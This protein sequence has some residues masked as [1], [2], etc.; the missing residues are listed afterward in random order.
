MS[1]V[2]LVCLAFAAGAMVLGQAAGCGPQKGAPAT[3]PPKII[4]E[5]VVQAKPEPAPGPKTGEP[6]KGAVSELVLPGASTGVLATERDFVTD[7]LVL[8]PLEFKESDFGGQ[9]QQAAADKEFM[10]NEGD[11]DGTQAA[12]KGT[13]WRVVRFT[14]DTRIGRVNL[15]KLYDAIDHA[16]AYAVAWLDCPA[17]VKDAKLLVGSDDYVKVW[18]N[19]R[20]VHTYKTERR[21]GAADQ[22]IV[23]G[24]ALKK[25][26][27]RV[28]VKCV[29]VVLDWDFY[30][31]LTDSA[32]KS[33][34]VKPKG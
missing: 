22:D 20:L 24:M 34:A 18:I 26:L 3:H 30:L 33:I 16:A 23:S 17:D 8:G 29:D 6:P 31:R 13:A 1:R 25:G 5:R 12:P 2:M 11:L 21:P 19:G 15:D 10:A 32:G 7:W 9:Q 28:V 27:N 4:K 14:D